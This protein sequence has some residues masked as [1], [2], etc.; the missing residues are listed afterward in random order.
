V[1][2]AVRL[3]LKSFGVDAVRSALARKSGL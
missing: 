2:K 1:K 3:R